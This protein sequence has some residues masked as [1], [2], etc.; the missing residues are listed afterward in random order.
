MELQKQSVINRPVE[1][2]AGGV[3]T[4]GWRMGGGP[5]YAGSTAHTRDTG[6]YLCACEGA[7]TA[8]DIPRELQRFAADRQSRELLWIGTA[9]EKAAPGLRGL[10]PDLAGRPP[11]TDRSAHSE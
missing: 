2:A 3:G 4:T 1:D 5:E 9:G 11:P 10:S 7:P 6:R 8:F